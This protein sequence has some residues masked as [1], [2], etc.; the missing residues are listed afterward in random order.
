[1]PELGAGAFVFREIRND[2]RCGFASGG[3]SRILGVRALGFEIGCVS[4]LLF[5]TEFLAWRRF[6]YGL[7]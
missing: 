5:R 2:A 6:A 1:M 3:A 7:V 4:S